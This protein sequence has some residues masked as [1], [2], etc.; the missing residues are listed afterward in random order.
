MKNILF[1]LAFII[2]SCS[3]NEKYRN[4]GKIS[5]KTEIGMSLEKFL[6]IAG[7]RAEKRDMKKYKNC[8]ACPEIEY[9]YYVVNQY[10]KND[11]IIDF[12]MYGFKNGIMNYA[13]SKMV[14]EIENK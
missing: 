11:K 13:K 3:E 5:N 1:V 2:F 12:M 10:D 6:E 8:K 4:I 14:L 7:T 9:L